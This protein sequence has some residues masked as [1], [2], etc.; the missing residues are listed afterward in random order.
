MGGPRAA[1]RA[2]ETKLT[3]W[4]ESQSRPETRRPW[5]AMQWRSSSY[6]VRWKS[7]PRK[8]STS[9]PTTPATSPSDASNARSPDDAGGR[10][11]PARPWARPMRRP[12]SADAAVP[13][14][15]T[16][17]LVPGGTRRHG[18]VTS[19]GGAFDSAPSSD[20]NVSPAQHAKNATKAWTSASRESFGPVRAWQ[21]AMHVATSE[22]ENTCAA[23]RCPPWRAVASCRSFVALPTLVTQEPVW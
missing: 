8:E 21:A 4:L 16:P 22:H 20:A 2:A 23:P 3:P 19:R 10:K 12:P 6:V 1:V 5:S 17:P 18:A 11:K 7:A 15:E 13:S 14:R 9:D